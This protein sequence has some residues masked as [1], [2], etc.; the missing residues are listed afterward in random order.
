MPKD[1]IS[2][3]IEEL[4]NIKPNL[5]YEY[6]VVRENMSD[7]IYALCCKYPSNI[8]EYYRKLKGTEFEDKAADL[9]EKYLRNFLR[10]S[11][12]RSTYQSFCRMLKGY[13]KDCGRENAKRLADN[14]RNEYYR[15][16]AFIDELNRAGF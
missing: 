13:A 8:T 12:S 14:L 9:Y 10:Q 7:R 2:E 3:K 11:A 4:L 5:S 1:K 6:I 16:P 15:R